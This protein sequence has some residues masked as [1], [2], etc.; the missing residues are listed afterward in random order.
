MNRSLDAF[1][2]LRRSYSAPRD[3]VFRAWTEPEAL[4]RWFKPRGQTTRVVALD[5]RAG[6]SYCFET[7]DADGVVTAISGRYVEI[8]PPEKLVFTWVSP[9]TDD[10]ETLVT[11]HFIDKAGATEITLSHERF[12]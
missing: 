5:L 7:R 9:S 2:N 3:L 1:L 4:E 10:A 12:S 11:L 8:V 6:G